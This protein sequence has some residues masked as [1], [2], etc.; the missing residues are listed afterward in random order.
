MGGLGKVLKESLG[1]SAVWLAAFL[2]LLALGFM[3]LAI[4]TGY[5]FHEKRMAQSAADAAAVAAA[6]EA[7][8]NDSGNMQTVANAISKMNGFD[9][10]AATSPATVQINSPPKYGSYAGCSGYTESSSRANCQRSCLASLVPREARCRWVH[11][12]CPVA[13]S[14]APPVSALRQVPAKA[15]T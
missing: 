6:E 1:Q 2:G 4:D 12:L 11:V 14:R 15:S 13:A 5:F 9:P 3:A 10:G 8:A 7:I